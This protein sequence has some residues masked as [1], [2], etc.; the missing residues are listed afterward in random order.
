MLKVRNHGYSKDLLEIIL[1]ATC[2]RLMEQKKQNKVFDID[3]KIKS[4]Y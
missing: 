3:M 1:V 4:P 2:H